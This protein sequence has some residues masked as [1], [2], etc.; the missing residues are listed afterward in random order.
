MSGADVTVE[1]HG[2]HVGVV[3]M[4]RPPNNYFDTALLEE[5]AVAYEGLDRSGWCRAVVLASEGRHFCA[6]LDLRELGSE[7]PDLSPRWPDMTKPVI[8]AING[9]AITGG[10][11]LALYCDILLASERATFADTHARVGLMPG[12]GMSV[13]LPQ[14]VGRQFARRMSLGSEFLTA[15]RARAVGLVTEVVPHE[16][17][18]D[19]ARAL[20]LSIT[21]NDQRAV[22]SMVGAYRQMDAVTDGP[23][24]RIEADVADEWLR[25]QDTSAVIAANREA[26]IRNGQAQSRRR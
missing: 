15:E 3:C 9:A 5:V 4:H 22:R 8:G 26:I 16:Q 23:S 7:L 2:D 21:A 25:S 1:Q 14:V 20:A 24:L 11:E 6:G 19:A 10:L 13:R 17:L 18:L 12:W